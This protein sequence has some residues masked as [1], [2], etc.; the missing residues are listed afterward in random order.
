MCYIYV[1]LINVV[2]ITTQPMNDTV[3]LTQSTTATFTCAVDRGGIPITNAGWRKLAEGIYV[4]V[5]GRPHHMTD[6]S[7]NGDI[8][9]DTLTVTDVSVNDNG[10]LYRCQPDIT[11]MMSMS[12]TL[13]V[14]GEYII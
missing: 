13:I 2:V 6:A 8:I 11:P 12:V 14:L 9:T 3:C 10:A 1:S 4:T 5:T 7:I